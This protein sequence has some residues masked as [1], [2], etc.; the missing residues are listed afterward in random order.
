M[1]GIKKSLGQLEIGASAFE[2]QVDRHSRKY[3]DKSQKGM[4]QMQCNLYY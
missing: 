2:S 1:Q 4:P 3:A